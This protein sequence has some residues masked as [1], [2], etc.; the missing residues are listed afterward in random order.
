[1]A[2]FSRF[3]FLLREAALRSQPDYRSFDQLAEIIRQITNTEFRTRQIHEN[4]HWLA[5]RLRR[6]THPLNAPRMIGM[7]AMRCIHA[8]NIHPALDQL[9]N[10]ARMVGRRA[11]RTNNLGSLPTLAGHYILYMDNY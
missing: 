4:R 9:L 11:E 3:A 6:V 8:R 5:E 10:N 7:I 1:M 2:A